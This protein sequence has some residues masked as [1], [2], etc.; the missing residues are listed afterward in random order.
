[1]DESWGRAFAKALQ[2]DFYA[3]SHIA[4]VTAHWWSID[5]LWK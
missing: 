1:M 2:W 3:T 5:C 4:I